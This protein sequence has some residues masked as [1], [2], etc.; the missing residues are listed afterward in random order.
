MVSRIGTHTRG[1]TTLANR[2]ILFMRTRMR[3]A[4][5]FLLYNVIFRPSLPCLFVW[6]RRRNMPKGSKSSPGHNYT[7]TWSIF[8][9]EPQRR[10]QSRPHVPLCGICRLKIQD[11]HKWK[12]GTQSESANGGAALSDRSEHNKAEREDDDSWP[13]SLR[14]YLQRAFDQ[15]KR[16]QGS[17]QHI[18]L[19][20]ALH[21]VVTDAMANDRMSSMDWDNEPLPR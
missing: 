17:R 4:T 10:R 12:T 7:L 3:V 21:R 8:I 6:L 9:D 5:F 19:E 15:C 14:R 13:P 1:V 16:K 18:Q 2:L 20:K 11:V